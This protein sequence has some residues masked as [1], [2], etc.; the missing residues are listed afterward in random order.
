MRNED[1]YHYEG[2]N[3]LAFNFPEMSKKDLEHA[4]AQRA[5]ELMAEG[6]HNEYQ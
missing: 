5:A 4:G 1:L 2:L 3:E 6:E